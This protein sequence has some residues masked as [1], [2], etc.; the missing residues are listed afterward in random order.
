MRMRAF[1]SSPTPGLA[2]RSVELALWETIFH[3]VR[4]LIL[5][6]L[7]LQKRPFGRFALNPTLQDVQEWILAYSENS[8]QGPPYQREATR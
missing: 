8:R 2:L 4:Q 7:M 1:P 5:T 6:T 3:R